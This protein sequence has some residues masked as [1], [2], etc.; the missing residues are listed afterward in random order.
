MAAVISDLLAE[1]GGL[2]GTGDMVLTGGSAGGMATFLNA[3]YV[4]GLVA[5]ANPNVHYIAYP[6]AGWF[7]DVMP[8]R[9]CN[10]PGVYECLCSASASC[11][12]TSLNEQ[13][14]V[15]VPRNT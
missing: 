12:V 6:D 8:N 2:A 5:A 14:P 3:D 15:A 1:D 7:M 11:G 9:V 4:K 13:M 10:S